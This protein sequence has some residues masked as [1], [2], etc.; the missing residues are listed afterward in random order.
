MMDGLL[1]HD[2]Y[3][4]EESLG[5]CEGSRPGKI[6]PCSQPCTIPIKG[7]LWGVY[8]GGGILAF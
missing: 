6:S 5:S 2:R 8:C 3:S 4:L 7:Q 1:D